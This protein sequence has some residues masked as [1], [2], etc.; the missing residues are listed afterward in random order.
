MAKTN[1]T[2]AKAARSGAATKAGKRAANVRAST[3]ETKAGETYLARAR[4]AKVD[5]AVVAL[6]VALDDEGV[7]VRKAYRAGKRT[8]AKRRANFA[9]ILCATAKPID[10]VNLAKVLDVDLPTLVQLGREGGLELVRLSATEFA[11]PLE[12]A[13]HLARRMREVAKKFG[14]TAK[15]RAARNRSTFLGAAGV[16]AGSR[17][18]YYGEVDSWLDTDAMLRDGTLT[19]SLIKSLRGKTLVTYGVPKKADGSFDWD[20]LGTNRMVRHV[21][22][23]SS[24]KIAANRKQIAALWEAQRQRS[25]LHIFG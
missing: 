15:S 18:A 13:L 25:D 10:F 9:A 21:R 22:K 17:K 16:P 12:S 23:Y 11:M 3:L 5:P 7:A 20:A 14:V 4:A 2:V 1:K 8:E 6:L 24:K 19:T